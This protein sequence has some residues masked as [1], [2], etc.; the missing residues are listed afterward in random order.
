[1]PRRTDETVSQEV[2]VG[3]RVPPYVAE[4]TRL[5]AEQRG[6]PQSTV[7]REYL[8]HG[9]NERDRGRRA[10]VSGGAPGR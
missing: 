7:L 8:Y 10:A 9:M 3:L 2:V 6:V 5:E 4:R 1:M